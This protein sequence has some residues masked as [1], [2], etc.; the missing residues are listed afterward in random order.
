M[1]QGIGGL[2]SFTGTTEPTLVR[3]SMGYAHP[4]ISPY[5]V[6]QTD[7]RPIV[8]AVRNDNQFYRLVSVLG[9][10]T[11]GLEPQ[12]S[13]LHPLSL[14]FETVNPSD[15]SRIP[16]PT[17]ERLSSTALPHLRLARTTAKSYPNL[18]SDEQVFD[19]MSDLWAQPRF[20]HAPSR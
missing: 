17:L 6:Y 3:R 9:F 5:E 14:G 18:I 13:A 15:K 12:I 7:D 11:L 8:I 1:A 19:K 2:M 16:W 4:S 10:P 20:L